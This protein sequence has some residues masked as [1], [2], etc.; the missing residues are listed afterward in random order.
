M[1]GCIPFDWHAE[2]RAYTAGETVWALGTGPTLEEALLVRDRWEALHVHAVDKELTTR[3]CAQITTHTIYFK[4]ATFE[5]DGVALV[6]WPVTHKTG[7]EQ[8]LQVART[9][10]YIGKNDGI[11]ACGSKGLWELLRTRR[12]LLERHHTKNDLIVFGAEL[13]LERRPLTREEAVAIPTW[14]ESYR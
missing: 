14:G 10:I 5:I 7:I 2:L 1:Y 12:V 8:L 3:Q 11:T 6:K 13:G 4:D 9:I